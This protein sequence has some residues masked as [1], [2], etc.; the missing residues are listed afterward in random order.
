MEVLAVVMMLVILTLVK[1]SEMGRIMG[2][3]GLGR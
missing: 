2:R 1:G 3:L